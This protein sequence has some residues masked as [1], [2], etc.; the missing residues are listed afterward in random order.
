[1]AIAHVLIDAK[2]HGERYKEVDGIEKG[3]NRIH[4]ALVHKSIVGEL[5]VLSCEGVLLCKGASW[6]L[7]GQMCVLILFSNE[8]HRSHVGIRGSQ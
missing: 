2:E 8:E 6:L 1:M 4:P 7:R 5:H 3:S